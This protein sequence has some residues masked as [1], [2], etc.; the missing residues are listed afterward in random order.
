MYELGPN[1][2]VNKSTRFLRADQ[3]EESE[4][5]TFDDNAN[6]NFIPALANLTKAHQYLFN[7]YGTGMWFGRQL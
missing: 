6:N 5:P 2:K 1:N 7:F 4:P 3:P